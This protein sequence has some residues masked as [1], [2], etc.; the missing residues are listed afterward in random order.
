MFIHRPDMIY[1]PAPSFSKML[2][3][4]ITEIK[5]WGDEGFPIAPKEVQLQREDICRACPHWE[6]G[7]YFNLGKCKLCGCSGMKWKLATA[8]CPDNPPRWLPVDI[9]PK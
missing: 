1:K 6:Q 4:T 2:T 9:Q 5:K 3:G 8:K 7:A